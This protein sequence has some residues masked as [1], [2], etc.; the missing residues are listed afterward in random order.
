MSRG[1]RVPFQP[2]SH[3]FSLKHEDVCVH[4]RTFTHTHTRLHKQTHKG[5]ERERCR[6]QARVLQ[7]GKTLIQIYLLRWRMMNH[8]SPPSKISHMH[9]VPRA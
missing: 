8:I 4:G 1:T 5:D 9:S 6:V 2:L 3:S 7:R